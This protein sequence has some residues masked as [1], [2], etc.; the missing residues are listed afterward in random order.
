[1]VSALPGTLSLSCACT[2]VVCVRERLAKKKEMGTHRVTQKSVLAALLV[3]APAP[4]ALLVLG[5][6]ARGW[7]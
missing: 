7:H 5:V 6:G 4:A 1:M 3:L 2:R